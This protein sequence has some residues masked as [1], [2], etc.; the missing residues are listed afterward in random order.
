MDENVQVFFS[1]P[2]PLRPHLLR[3]S[4]HL[5]QE[6]RSKGSRQILP[7]EAIV[8]ETAHADLSPKPRRGK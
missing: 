7:Q 8:I 2:L 1:V 3:R 5:R 6:G 4:R